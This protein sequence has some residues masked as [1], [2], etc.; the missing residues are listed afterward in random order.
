MRYKAPVILN[1]KGKPVEL[2]GEERYRAELLQVRLDMEF[3]N[4]L[5]SLRNALGYEISITTLTTIMKRITEQKFFE[6]PPADYIPVRV[7]EG[8]WS[9]HLTTYRSFDAADTFETGII[10]LGGQNARLANVDAAVDALSIQVFNWAKSLGWSI[11]DL[12]LAAK[13]GNWDIVA[14][15]EKARKRNWDLGVQRIAFL[16]AD[17]QNGNNGNCL[18]LL[19]QSGITT[20]TT[21]ITKAI[22]TMTPAEL[23]VFVALIVET[24][25][26]NCNRT[27]WPTHFIIPESDYNGL[28]SQASDTFPIKSTKQLL[29]EAFKEIVPYGKFKALLPLAYADAAYHAGVSQIANKQIYTLLNYDEESIRMDVPVD[30]TSTLANSIDNFSFQNAAYGQFT[31]VLAYRPLELLYFTY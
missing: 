11:F 23:K 7:G 18:G 6:V 24:Y 22:S 19:N 30:Y 25:R 5:P 2:T 8:A 29:E 14:A 10:N 31:G 21:V 13:S 20:N 17:G 26:A 27:A 9:T 12:E 16:G 4:S 15:K 1:S 3:K 28:A